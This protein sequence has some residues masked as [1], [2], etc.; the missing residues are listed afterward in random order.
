MHSYPELF[1][2]PILVQ[3]SKST[4]FQLLEKQSC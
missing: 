3:I 1:K 2:K 4:D